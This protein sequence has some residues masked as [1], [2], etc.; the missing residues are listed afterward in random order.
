MTRA[1]ICGT[2][3]E[4]GEGERRNLNSLFI[5]MRTRHMKRI[6]LRMGLLNLDVNRQKY[7][8]KRYISLPFYSLLYQD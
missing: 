3:T 5:T 7:L 2:R 4:V 6:P 1:G 8:A